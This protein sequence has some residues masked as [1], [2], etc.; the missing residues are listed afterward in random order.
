M[1]TFD[2]PK[3]VVSKCI[4][5]DNCRYDGQMIKSNFVELIKPYVDFMPVCAE[6]EIG[7]GIPRS[8]I[9]IISA[10]NEYRLIQP[11]TGLD[12]TDKMNNFIGSFFASQKGVDGFILKSR[13]PSCGL[14]DARIYVGLGDSSAI[15]RDSG[16]FGGAVLRIAPNLAIEDEGRLKNLRIREHFLTKLYALVAFRQAKVVRSLQ[17]LKNFH[18]TNKL[19]LMAHC[20]QEARAMEKLLTD[21]DPD[22]HRLLSE[23]EAHLSRIL[24][25]PPRCTN[26]IY[27]M[28]YAMERLADLS[29]K[30]KDF[31][32]KSLEQY[33]SRKL[34]LSAPLSVLKEWIV[35]FDEIYLDDQT[36]FEPYPNEIV[37]LC[38]NGSSDR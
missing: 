24:A 35:R 12:L 31:F 15:R 8:P 38:S 37:E 7:L 4:E 14:K 22:I 10:D 34:P 29:Q 3:I 2:R 32:L 11:A 26:N 9:R 27:V 1:R 16:F 13:S 33:R 21:K 6:V 36:Y 20:L 19:L 25:R 28:K 5:H 17:K 30:E 23:Y 18:Y